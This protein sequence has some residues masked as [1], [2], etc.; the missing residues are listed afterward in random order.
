[1]IELTEQ[2]RRALAGTVDGPVLVD[3]NTANPYVLLR[4]D[5]YDRLIA[6]LD[7]DALDMHQ[8]A[9]LVDRAMAED[10][11]HDPLLAD[12]QKYRKSP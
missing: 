8:V 5:I 2:Q 6:G 7:D 3:A 9:V 10:D 12:Y 1:M 4:K 11:A